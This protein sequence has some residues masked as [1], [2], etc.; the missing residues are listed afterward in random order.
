MGNEMEEF[1]FRVR[2][3][4]DKRWAEIQWDRMCSDGYRGRHDNGKS[5]YKS[6]KSWGRHK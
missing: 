4:T 5:S 2:D 3:N 1:R 6:R